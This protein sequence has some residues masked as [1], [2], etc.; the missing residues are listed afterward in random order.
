MVGRATTSF[1]DLLFGMNNGALSVSSYEHGLQPSK[2]LSGLSSLWGCSLIMGTPESGH[3]T[4]DMALCYG[5]RS[6]DFF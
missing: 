4:L 6:N 2:P 3:N 5:E 1:F